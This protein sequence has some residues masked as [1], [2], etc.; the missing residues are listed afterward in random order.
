MLHSLFGYYFVTKFMLG[1]E[2]WGLVG[3]LDS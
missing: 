2:R 1:E 3:F